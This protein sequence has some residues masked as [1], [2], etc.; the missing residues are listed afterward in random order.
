MYNDGFYDDAISFF[1]SAKLK[2]DG[3]SKALSSVNDWITRARRAKASFEKFNVPEDDVNF[4]SIGGVKEVPYSTGS[5]L[6]IVSN[7]EW[8]SVDLEDGMIK[9]TAK[10]NLDMENRIGDVVFR[11][12][13][14]KMSSRGK[15]RQ[16]D[17]T[18][19]INQD[20]RVAQERTVMFRTKPA[21]VAITLPDDGM[22]GL[23]SQSYTLSEGNHRAVL[24]KPYYKKQEVEF[25]ISPD[26]PEGTKYV[27]VELA[28]QFALVH[29]N[30]S[31]LD[32]K[33]I[34]KE[35]NPIM[36]IG[37]YDLDPMS[38]LNDE[39]LADIDD[40]DVLLGHLYKGG[41]LPLPEGDYAI[42]LEA[43]GFETFNGRFTAR[44][45][46]ELYYDVT[47][48]PIQGVLKIL[49]VG[50]AEGAKIFVD[51]VEMGVVPATLKVPADL[52]TVVLEKE[53]Y[54]ASSL[55]YNVEVAP[56]EEQTISVA[57]YP[58]AWISIIT[59]PAGAAVSIG[60]QLFNSPVTYYRIRKGE[61]NVS[62]RK[63]GYMPIEAKV[64]AASDTVA[65]HYDLLEG[66]PLDMKSDEDGLYVTLIDKKSNIVMCDT[67][68]PAKVFIPYGKYKVELR[69]FNTR[70]YQYG[71]NANTYH[72]VSDY[73]I[74]NVT[75]LDDLAYKGNL[76]FTPKTKGWKR[77]TF[78]SNSHLN[79]LY[80]SYWL[81]PQTFTLEEPQSTIKEYG[82]GEFLRFSPFPGYTTSLA[83]VSI[84]DVMLES[85]SKLMLGG[86]IL[87]T[88]GEFR[89]G[90]PL[91]DLFDVSLLG[92]YSWKP[93]FVK[94]LSIER[95]CMA[96]FNYF[97]GM[98][99][100]TRF[101]V[102]DFSFRFG[103]QFGNKSLV[104]YN[105]SGGA[106]DKYLEYTFDASGLVFSV[107]MSLGSRSSKGQSILRLWK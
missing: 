53:G 78:S 61:H 55:A 97:V 52:H 48:T 26:E 100:S 21:G 42:T 6:T 57:M 49:D 64:V 103:Q 107:S 68:L 30:I 87:F 80:G 36:K 20:P 14:P 3:D 50:G 84:N 1:E 76:N 86:S 95:N 102:A 54:I 56:Y 35:S 71:Q 75:G 82:F 45:G 12:I 70:R 25:S 40:D 88:N 4:F 92:S 19:H 27:D 67:I 106:N 46:N 29:L 24:T 10:P 16:K 22:A 11:M 13:I 105:K 65:F 15:A 69:R 33:T 94:Y 66:H 18:I 60:G 38:V 90:G 104:L 51:R 72:S 37:K 62:I 89:L 32:V 74:R 91:H 43:K 63:D 99:L 83:E 96:G 8:C 41:L 81:T 9:F 77:H 93:P 5:P 98:E 28:P 79:L 17:L 73:D 101:P 44:E 31:S 7:P 2:V 58:Q 39:H 47:L 59:E 23:S 85:E 34:T